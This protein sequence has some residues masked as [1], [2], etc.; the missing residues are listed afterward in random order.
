M[1]STIQRLPSLNALR[2]FAVAAQHLSFK[3][4]AEALHVTPAA[5]SQQIRLLEDSLGVKLFLRLN[6]SLQLTDVGQR[7]LPKLQEGFS[8]FARALEDIQGHDDSKVLTVNVA[9]SFAAKWLV[10]RLHRFAATYREIDMRVAASTTVIDG[11]DIVEM[12]E[13]R[14]GG[15][16]LT[17]RFGRGH[18]PGYR[19]EKLFSVS[20]VPM[21]SPHLLEG[22]PPLQQPTDLRHHRLLHDDIL[23]VDDRRPDWQTWLKAAGVEGVDTNRGQHF[24][25]T[26][27]ALDAAIEGQGV[28][29]SIK[30][31]ALN[32]LLAGR[33]VIPFDLP[34]PLDFAY[35]VVCPEDTADQPKIA[36]FRQWLREEAER[37]KSLC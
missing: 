28:V 3:Q 26:S 5:V 25:H 29:L 27:L 35:H 9:P 14:Q 36:A 34:I 6:R 18:Y 8:C 23:T 19:V 20:I 32:D 24:N 15:V 12:K 16:D 17:V 4:A 1:I 2:A 22:D 10:P 7:F 30:N 37:D 31:L 13:F 21:C 11:Q 33:L